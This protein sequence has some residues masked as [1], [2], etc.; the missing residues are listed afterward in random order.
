[1]SAQ[2]IPDAADEADEADKA[3]EAAVF[4]DDDELCQIAA[5]LATMIPIKVP[6]P[7][8]ATHALRF[9]GRRSARCA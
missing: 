9:H 3:D 4:R 6:R 2:V 1:M 5:E 7:I 8:S